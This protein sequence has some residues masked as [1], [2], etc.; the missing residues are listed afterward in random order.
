MDHAMTS[1]PALADSRRLRFATFTWLYVAQGVG[2][3][4]F[5]YAFPPYLA[6]R[7]F[8]PAAI[9]G[10]AAV[11]VLPWSLKL[12]AGPL[13]DRWTFRAMG[14]RRPWVLGAEMGLLVASIAAAMIPSPLDHLWWLI[15]A[16]FMLNFFLAFQDVAIDGMAIDL[17]PLGEQGRANALMFGGQAVGSAAVIVGGVWM[18][19]VS[20]PAGV[21]L[22]LAAAAGVT[23][24]VLLL[25]RERG[26]E[27][28]LPW[29]AGQPAPGFEPAR[30]WRDI[31][32]H[33]G[34]TVVLPTGIVAV[35]GLFAY[36][37]GQ[38]LINAVLPV[39]A[40]QD[41]GWNDTTYAEL[42]AAAEFAAAVTS[43]IVFGI[44]IDRFGAVRMVRIG[45]LVVIALTMAMGMAAGYWPTRVVL[46]SF[47]VAYMVSNMLIVVAYVAVMMTL[48][49][50]RVAATQFGLY[51]ALSNLGLSTGAALLGPLREVAS[52]ASMV[53][54]VAACYAFMLACAGFVSL[55]RHR[56]QVARLDAEETVAPEWLGA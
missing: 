29:S 47:V 28:L 4:L 20:G 19:N 21:F 1:L 56:E 11:T 26:G 55:T 12:V 36:R 24:L 53:F 54:V 52:Y 7:G 44:L 40:V 46:E 23:F 35:A 45:A 48:C 31:G 41:L 30:G 22:L 8:S 3:G 39:V 13:M 10:F 51:M 25:V 38:G 18:L 6:E 2:F 9:G 27:R 50:P 33:L 15:A 5:L 43:M 17:L 49:R 16:G 42:R 37:T 14:R 34:R 32:R